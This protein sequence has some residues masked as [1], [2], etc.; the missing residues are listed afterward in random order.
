MPTCPWCSGSGTE[1]SLPDLSQLD[2]KRLAEGAGVSR[3]LVS[4]ML[5]DDPLVRRANP[6]LKTLQGL[7]RCIESE[8]GVRVP[9]DMIAE[10]ISS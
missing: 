4:R 10:L 2:Q 8:R 9:L 1:R 7:Q 6:T 5:S 3:S